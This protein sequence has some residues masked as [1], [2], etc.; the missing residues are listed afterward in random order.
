MDGAL[1]KKPNFFLE[2]T[3]LVIIFFYYLFFVLLILSLVG[4]FKS[5]CIV[6]S[7]IIFLICLLLFRKRIRTIPTKTLL[8][9]GLLFI[10]TSFVF[11]GCFLFNGEFSGDAI[12][13][14][15]PLSR[16]ITRQSAM[17]NLLLSSPQFFTSKAP[18]LPLLF[19]GT[20]TFL[21]FNEIFVFWIP[22][23][24]SFLTLLLL[25]KWCKLKNIKR[26]YRG[27]I[28]LLFLASPLILT[29]GWN[30]VRAPLV[31]FFFVAFFYYFEKYKKEKGLLDFILLTLSLVLAIAS[32]E[33]G[34]L[35]IIPFSFVFFKKS[36]L[37][38]T[39]K[40]L[41]I[42]MALP[43]IVW[44]IRNYLI[45][46]NPIFPLLND[47]FK[48]RYYEFPGAHLSYVNDYSI[49]SIFERFSPDVF[50][51]FLIIVPFIIV[52]FY[53]FFKERKFEYL[54]LFLAMFLVGQF[55]SLSWV[56]SLIR[57]Y[58]PFLGILLVYFLYG[59][60]GVKSRKILS[61][62]VFISLFGLFST[63]VVLSKS[64]FIGPI[65]KQ[66]RFLS[67]LVEFIYNYKLIIALVL[68]LFFYFVL[69]RRKNAK[70]LILLIVGFYLLKTYSIQISWLN[71]WLPILA[72]IAVIIGWSLFWRLSKE[73]LGQVI[74]VI[75]GLLLLLN[76]WGLNA[77]YYL[78]NNRFPY[79]PYL[80]GSNILPASEER[81]REIE[82]EN[83]DF[84]VLSDHPG[85]LSWYYDYKEVDPSTYTFNYITNLKYK[86]SMTAEEL[87]RL[88]KE[89]RIKYIIKSTDKDYWDYLFDKV[90]DR[91]NLFKP[92]LKQNSYI[93]WK[94]YD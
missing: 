54:F 24:F 63:E 57:H 53:V 42:G 29:W 31:L 65:E 11:I 56:G 32:E 87:R 6:V 79:H 74:M 3:D 1:K 94:V 70:Y 75:I 62:L 82:R 19:A 68:A 34:L 41:V 20:F 59:L 47:F 46:D 45:F 43:M 66:I 14:W 89:A 39:K 64:L 76:T 77:G 69:S 30:L 93:L 71:I 26:E 85:Y 13:D 33:T 58:Y 37:G 52:A 7:L 10:I 15:L 83:K 40:F 17:P 4:I 2:S 23:L 21:P 9:C 90:K 28:L 38:M 92:I 81:I 55:W 25:Y 50:L 67:I 8:K 12:R 91:P 84:Y 51:P 80:W 27:F 78:A 5:Y 49:G 22:V 61:F 16:E 48:G 35:L 60:V 88:L 44:W 18:F 86:H 73:R 36:F 72:L